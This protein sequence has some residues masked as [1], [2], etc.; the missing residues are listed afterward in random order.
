MPNRYKS[1]VFGM[2]N[3]ELR[4]NALKEARDCFGDDA[5]LVIIEDYDVW[6]SGTW[7]VDQKLGRE[8]GRRFIAH[9]NVAVY[10][11]DEYEPLV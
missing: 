8:N 7:D 3:E 4:E 6:E 9:I 5:H 1:T 10:R 2:N 11:D